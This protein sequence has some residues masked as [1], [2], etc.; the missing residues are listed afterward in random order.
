[1][2]I[3]RVIDYPEIRLNLKNLT[4]IVW[5]TGRTPATA[6]DALFGHFRTAGGVFN[7]TAPEDGYAWVLEVSGFHQTFHVSIKDA[8]I[9]A[10]EFNL[11]GL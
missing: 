1:M 8:R 4:D 2:L 11:R 3:F 10:A 9:A 5:N 6:K 7:L